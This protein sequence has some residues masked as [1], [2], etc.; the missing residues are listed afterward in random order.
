[1][2]GGGPAARGSRR[3]AKQPF[4]RRPTPGPARGTLNCEDA[5]PAHTAPK[6]AAVSALLLAA[7]C[8]LV[9]DDGP[10]GSVRH[11]FTQPPR[12]AGECFARNAEAH[13]SA[14]VAEVR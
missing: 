8:T 14:L 4:P 6:I 7:G 10:A 9:Q 12:P 13:S 1:L 2:P 5:M 3:P 11:A